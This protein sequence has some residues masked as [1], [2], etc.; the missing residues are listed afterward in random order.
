M[1]NATPTAET[2]ISTELIRA[3]LQAQMPE[4]ADL[5]LVHQASGWDNEIYRVGDDLALRMPRRTLSG[6]LVAN[7]QRWLPE[8]GPALPLPVPIPVLAGKPALGYPWPWSVVPWFEGIPLAHSPALD[9]D[10]LI[11]D[12]TGFLNAL[13]VEADPHAPINEHRGIPLADRDELTRDRIAVCDGID[14]E[15]VEDLWTELLETPAFG[16]T[17][18][19]LHG[20]LHPLN[21]L[22]RGG[23]LA[24]VLDFGDITSGDPATDL[25]IA[26]M[27]FDDE[28]RYFFRSECKIDGRSVDIHTWKR[29]R[30][31]ALSIAIMMLSYSDDNPTLRRIG[32]ATLNQVL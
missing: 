24:A 3:L 15:R 18:V 14:T 30:G 31:W 6:A 26:W 4:L 8:I 10:R 19:W 7:E 22:V 2:T 21:M 32:M 29:A 27:L 23:R 28:G 11:S 17:P 5:P 25:A 20:D 13:H 1:P 9:Q 16:G 12:L